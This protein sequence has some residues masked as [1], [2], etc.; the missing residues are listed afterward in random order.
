MMIFYLYYVF[1]A[2]ILLGKKV[3]VVPWLL[4]M[5]LLNDD[6][7]KKTIVIFIIFVTC[8]IPAGVFMPAIVLGALFGRL[9]GEFFNYYLAGNV[10]VRM[11]SVAGAAGFAAVITRTIS[12]ILIL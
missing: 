7:L 11:T 5:P 9:Y 10:N 4:M 8:P 12:P 6:I 3:L 1:S 2:S